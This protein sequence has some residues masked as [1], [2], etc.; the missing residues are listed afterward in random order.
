MSWLEGLGAAI[1]VA[2]LVLAVRKSRWA[3]VLTMVNAVVYG[4][5]FWNAGLIFSTSLQIL[6]LGLAGY[7]FWYW[8][9]RASGVGP[10]V[11]RFGFRNT[12]LV[13]FLVTAAMEGL[14]IVS[15]NYLL[16]E[17][18]HADALVAG[19]SIYGEA[20]LSR[21]KI[22]TWPIFS[23]AYILAVYT[24]LVSALF[25]TAA[26]CALL[27]ALSLVG[28]WNWRKSLIGVA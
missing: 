19:L 21:K 10:S 15:G 13:L 14:A 23:L 1:A 26:L 16:G 20:L 8:R 2:I 27:F 24:Y 18:A 5:V 11:T 17:H 4:L 7:G 22:E 25:F 28:W 6:F 12:V 3:F 9:A